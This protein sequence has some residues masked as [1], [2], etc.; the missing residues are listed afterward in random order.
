[1]LNIAN[2]SAAIRE[3]DKRTQQLI[4]SHKATNTSM[5]GSLKVPSWKTL[6]KFLP[7]NKASG[8]GVNLSNKV[9][10]NAHTPLVN[11]FEIIKR[12]KMLLRS[13]IFICFMAEYNFS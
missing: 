5:D 7:F 2:V 1:M 8:H 3:K 10:N 9:F 12:A 11:S 13:K 6:P 4:F